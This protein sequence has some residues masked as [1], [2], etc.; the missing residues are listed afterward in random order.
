M[1]WQFKMKMPRENWNSELR[2][3]LNMLLSAGC[4]QANS[5]NRTPDN[6]PAKAYHPGDQPAESDPGF[7]KPPAEAKGRWP[8]S[9]DR[10]TGRQQLP[11]AGTDRRFRKK[12]DGYRSWRCANTAYA[13]AARVLPTTRKPPPTTASRPSPWWTSWT[14]TAKRRCRGSRA[15]APRRIVG[16]NHL[17]LRLPR[18]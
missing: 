2:L 3:A 9:F 11:P 5:A 12:V 16:R 14:P 10:R 18:R 7:A 4:G 1:N 17:E 8:S 15:A 13:E 6:T